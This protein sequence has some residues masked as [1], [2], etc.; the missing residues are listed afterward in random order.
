MTTKQTYEIGCHAD[1]WRGNAEQ[2][3]IVIGLVED[4]PAELISDSDKTWI[5]GE[6]NTYKQI[7]ADATS[8]P[9]AISDAAEA[10]DQVVDSSIDK[11]NDATMDERPAFTYWAFEDGD[12]G[13]WPDVENMAED[14][15]TLEVAEIPDYIYQVSDHGNVSVFRVMAVEEVWSVV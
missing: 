15:S 3:D 13:L 11:L 10:I 7:V 4:L 8:A 14:E 5:V 9:D 1:S 12:F 2:N 6:Y